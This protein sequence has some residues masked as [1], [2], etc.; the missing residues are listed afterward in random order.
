MPFEEFRAR[1]EARH[2]EYYDGICVVNP[3]TGQHERV[4]ASLYGALD[5]ACPASHEVLMGWGW[6]TGPERWFSPDLMV[7]DRSSP[8]NDIL[9]TPPP[10]LVVEVTSP[11]TRA[12]DWGVKRAAYAQA[13]ASWYWIVSLD[14]PEVVV[15]ENT[16]GAFAERARIRTVSTVPGPLFAVIDPTSFPVP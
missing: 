10:L 8:D 16:R 6:E 1:G 14:P 4:V 15:M 12:D 9:R 7:S 5:A 2:T 3:P 13:G 11:S